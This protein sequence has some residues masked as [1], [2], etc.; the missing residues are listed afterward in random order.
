[1]SESPWKDFG[2]PWKDFG[3]GAFIAKFWVY[4]HVIESYEVFSYRKKTHLRTMK[5]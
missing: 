4:I 2:N 3:V 1:M 5:N